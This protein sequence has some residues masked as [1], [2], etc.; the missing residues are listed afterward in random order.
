MDSGKKDS[1]NRGHSG[2][3]NQAMVAEEWYWVLQL[4]T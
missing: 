3:I 1:K 4:S 2:V